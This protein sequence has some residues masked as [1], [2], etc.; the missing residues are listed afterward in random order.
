MSSRAPR[1][2]VI[3]VGRKPLLRYVLA[4]I[5]SLNRGSEEVVVRGRGR[6]VSKCVDVVMTLKR[7]FF[8]DLEIRGISVGTDEVRI[9]ERTINLSYIEVRVG[10]RKG[11]RG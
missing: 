1:T 9:G 4:T 7:S 6:S 3:I 2:E 5:T 8:R 10:R 11:V